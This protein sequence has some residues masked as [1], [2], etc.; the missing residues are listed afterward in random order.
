MACK[1]PLDQTI[2]AML[3]RQL[4]L[5]HYEQEEFLKAL[6]IAKQMAQLKALP[7]VCHQDVARAWIALNNIDAAVEHLRLAARNAPARR[8]S[9]HL[10][11]LGS[12]LFLAR[13]F[14]D[15]ESVLKRAVRWATTDRPL[16]AGH[17][18]LVQLARGQQ[19]REIGSIVEQLEHSPCGQGYGRFVLGM[20]CVYTQRSVEAERYLTGFITRTT[21]GRKALALC[22]AGEVA[23]AQ[24]Y[25]RKISS[26]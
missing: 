11:T 19:V 8:R 3:M 7:D 13:R 23:M 10:W 12:V 20:L 15:A 25:V 9:F 22:L 26:N 24:E 18:A 21:S 5:A 16:C 1:A 2:Q 4:Y 14:E 6:D 17:L